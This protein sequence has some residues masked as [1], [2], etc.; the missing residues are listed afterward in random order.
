[1]EYLLGKC[2][3]ENKLLGFNNLLKIIQ[4][5]KLISQTHHIEYTTV[6][7]LFSLRVDGGLVLEYFFLPGEWYRC[8]IGAVVAAEKG[9]GSIVETW[10]DVLC[11]CGGWQ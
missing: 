1:M 2:A 8:H 5:I 6:F 7:T 3:K 9:A 4:E 10:G 11:V